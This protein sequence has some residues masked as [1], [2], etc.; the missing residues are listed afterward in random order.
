MDFQLSDEML[1]L[2]QSVRRLAQDKVK[3]RAREIDE[4]GEYPQ[5]LFEV[6]RDAGA[7]RLSLDEAF[8]EADILS[9]HVPLIAGTHHLVSADRLRS[10]KRTAILINTSRGGL[11]DTHSLASALREGMIAGA[12]LD[13]FEGEVESLLQFQAPRDLPNRR[14]QRRK[15]GLIA[16]DQSNGAREMRQERPRL[17]QGR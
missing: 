9:V 1:G 14:S 2:Q 7:R 5:D 11:V 15:R 6:F 16:G 4:T 12:G 8:A 10:M 13:V 3:P 17:R